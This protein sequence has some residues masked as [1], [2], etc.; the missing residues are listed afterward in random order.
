MLRLCLKDFHAELPAHIP[1][2]IPVAD[3]AEVLEEA[4]KQHEA[5][6]DKTSRQKVAKQIMG[7]AGWLGGKQCSAN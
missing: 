6:K 4:A 2:T 5:D 7:N 3:I 1:I